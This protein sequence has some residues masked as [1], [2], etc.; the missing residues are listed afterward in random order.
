[1]FDE[2]CGHIVPVHVLVQLLPLGAGMHH[3]KPGADERELIRLKDLPQR[4]PNL[5]SQSNTTL[6][7]VGNGHKLEQHDFSRGRERTQTERG[8]GASQ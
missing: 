2:A 3:H 4:Y 5:F 6:L 8:R 7:A 1:M